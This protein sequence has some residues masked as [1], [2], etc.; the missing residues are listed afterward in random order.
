MITPNIFVGS[1]DGYRQ[2]VRV[3]RG[4]ESKV[5]CPRTCLWTGMLVDPEFN[6]PTKF[7]YYNPL[8]NAN[9]PHHHHHQTKGWVGTKFHDVTEWQAQTPT[10]I[11]SSPCQ[12]TWE[13]GC[14]NPF[15]GPYVYFALE[16]RPKAYYVKGVQRIFHKLL[17]GLGDIWYNLGTV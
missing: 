17:G 5:S 8:Q 11:P 14:A 9:P 2:T 6:A 13:R 12:R 7:Y 10:S 16:T 3:E 1:I 15:P 4:T